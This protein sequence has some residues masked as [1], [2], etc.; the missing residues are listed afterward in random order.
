LVNCFV[1]GRS[2][3]FYITSVVAGLALIAV[4]CF[5]SP[6]SPVAWILLPEGKVKDLARGLAVTVSL[7][8]IASLLLAAARNFGP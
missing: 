4:Y 1:Y 5:I 3:V 2:F 7:A 6:F 8:L